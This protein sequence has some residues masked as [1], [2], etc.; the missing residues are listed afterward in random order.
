MI[1]KIKNESVISLLLLILIV[2]IPI[3]GFLLNK[4]PNAVPENAPSTEFSAVRAMKHLEFI[5]SEPHPLEPMR[6]KKSVSISLTN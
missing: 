1:T 3:V 2:V 6:M 5:A 4:A